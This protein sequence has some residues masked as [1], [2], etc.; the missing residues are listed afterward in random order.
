MVEIVVASVAFLMIKV[1]STTEEER[2]R[3]G[4]CLLL[5]YLLKYVFDLECQIGWRRDGVMAHKLLIGC[6]HCTTVE[7]SPD[8]TGYEG[9]LRNVAQ[10]CLYHVPE[11]SDLHTTIIV[12]NL[13][14]PSRSTMC[15]NFMAHDACRSRPQKSCHSPIIVSTNQPP[16]QPHFQSSQ[17]LAPCHFFPPLSFSH[18]NQPTIH[19]SRNGFTPQPTP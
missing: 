10:V 6:P 5:R 4:W 12:R 11:L 16:R 19:A 9:P 3:R 7:V 15:H 8:G 1:W 17:L 13:L 18:P 14:C 2:L